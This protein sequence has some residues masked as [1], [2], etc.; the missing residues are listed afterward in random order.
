MEETPLE[1][2]QKPSQKLPRIQKLRLRNYISETT[3]QKQYI[4]IYTYIYT[5]IYIFKYIDIHT[6]DIN[7]FI[8]MYENK[9]PHIYHICKYQ[10]KAI[11]IYINTS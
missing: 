2:E 9:Y 11:Y 8:H 10:K 6:V 7:I 3:S 5:N 4:Y 1:D